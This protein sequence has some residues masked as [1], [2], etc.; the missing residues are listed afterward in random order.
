MPV[1]MQRNPKSLVT[2]LAAVLL[3]ACAPKT[4]SPPAS[5]TPPAETNAAA[6]GAA[7]PVAAVAP[8]TPRWQNPGGMWM[9]QQLAAQADTLKAL[10]FELDPASF[11][12]PTGTAL[13]SIVSL[14]GCSA[15]FVSPDGLIVTNH[16]CVQGA[17]QFNATPEANLIQDGY[18][19]KTRADEKFAG[20]TQHVYVTQ[21][22][23]DVTAAM[24]AGLADVKDDLER[25]KTLELREKA[26]LATCEKD[27]PELRCR[28]E[29]FFGGKAWFLIEQVDLKD[30]RL[31]YAPAHGVGN[32]GGEVDNWRWP[33]HTGDFAFLRAYVGKDGKPAGYAPENVPFRP[34]HFMK[35]AQKPLASG[36]F[37]MVAGFPGSTHRLSDALTIE[38]AAT[39]EYPH[40]VEIN[41]QQLEA[42][43]QVV[44]KNAQLAIKAETRKRGLGNY[45]TKYRGQ[46]ET[47][48]KRD[49]VAT[50]KQQDADLATWVNAD[51][52]R[53]GKYG[54]ALTKLAAIHA[55]RQKTRDADQAFGELYGAKSL[56]G[57]ALTIVRKA[58]ERTKNDADRELAFQERN[59]ERLDQDQI[60]FEKSY[61][62]EL[63]RAILKLFLGRALA[64]PVAQQPAFL[65][66]WLPARQRDAKGIDRALD[67]LYATTRLEDTKVR[68]G[69]LA[70]A[71][72]AQLAKSKDPFV[73]LALAILP[74]VEAKEARDKAYRGALVL[75]EPLYV[76]AL[77]DKGGHEL[78]PDANGTL[79]ITYGTVQPSPKGGRAFTT[80]SEMVAK[81]TGEPPFNAPAA[82]LAA[83]KARKFGPYAAA[84]LQ[85]DL[86]LDF[87]SDLDITNG[88]SGSS[89]INAR[90]ELVGLA[91]DGTYESVASDWLYLDGITRTIHCDLRYALWI[92]DAVDGADALLQEMGVRP[93]L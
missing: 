45:L 85:G 14:G 16:H 62:R 40:L 60:A 56:L 64:L 1:F 51:P 37:V 27:R 78:A 44:G 36:D 33:R 39:W 87:M 41:Q 54:A 70:S 31:V 86:P 43:D 11:A 22:Y 4:S 49:L 26:L 88:N 82:L 81:A 77:E 9:P 72:P 38:E 90:G 8:V 29:K 19:A 71:T 76:A 75:A 67:R 53:A 34:A 46:L 59:W 24:T 48:G 7:A 74:G 73:Q 68:L 6:A 80:V 20:P 63:D 89:T 79:R 69:L 91:F 3:A 57:S 21:K 15:T 30:V 23:S 47:F 35:L 42:I 61:A 12:D 58:K 13:G 55:E 2:L 92:M 18:L 25:G 66:T 10:G 5:T 32:F 83:A 93:A 52:E 28:V 50:R 84:E 65:A 17:L